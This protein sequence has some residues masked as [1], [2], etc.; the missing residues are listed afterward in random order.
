[1]SALGAAEVGLE[2]LHEIAPQV[3]DALADAAQRGRRLVAHLAV[4]VERAPEQV[5]QLGLPREARE[6]R[7]E[8]GR[9]RLDGAAVGEQAPRRLQQR[10][11]R[12]QVRGLGHR[13]HHARGLERGPHVRDALPGRHAG[14]AHRGPGLAGLAERAPD[15]AGI[16]ERERGERQ[17]SPHRRPRLAG[18]E[19]QHLRPLEAA[20]ARGE[21]ER[22]A[23]ARGALSGAPRGRA[24]RPRPRRRPPRSSPAPRER[25]ARARDRRRDP[26]P[27]RAG[28]AGRCRS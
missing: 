13:A 27:R 21:P 9:H 26:G 10:D 3:A 14:L 5:G 4:G 24:P 23:H 6:R 22:G 28:R 25:R 15:R 18:E 1:M 2:P 19:R 12:G 7:R 11:Q 20:A 17:L 16:G 8:I